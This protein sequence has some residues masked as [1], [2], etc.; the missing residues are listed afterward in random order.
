MKSKSLLGLFS[1]VAEPAENGLR[2]ETKTAG[3]IG[4]RSGVG[5]EKKRANTRW[6]RL[7][8]SRRDDEDTVHNVLFF[9]AKGEH[10][11]KRC[12]KEAERHRN[13]SGLM[14]RGQGVVGC[15]STRLKGRLS[16]AGSRSL[17]KEG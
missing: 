16:N 9:G 11:C 2:S 14:K 5:K 4:Q 10:V 17:L 13:Y 15:H 3:S 6:G 12:S 7:E 8:H 1:N